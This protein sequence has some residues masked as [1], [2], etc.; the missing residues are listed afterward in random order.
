MVFWVLEVPKDGFL[1]TL[2]KHRVMHFLASS[3]PKKYFA[4]D[5]YCKVVVFLAY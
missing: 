5:D 1:I 3:L 4:K 2:G